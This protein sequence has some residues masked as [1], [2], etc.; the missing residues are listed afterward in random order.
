MEKARAIA[1]MLL[2]ATAFAGTPAL[3][4]QGSRWSASSSAGGRVCGVTSSSWS[5]GPIV[6]ASL[7]T[8]QPRGVFQ[9]VS[10]DV[11]LRLVHPRRR[12]VNAERAEPEVTGLPVEQA[13]EDAW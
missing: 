6:S 3:A 9:V 10:T 4:Q 11:G 5:R 8:I 1:T 2:A 12:V 13:A 7:T